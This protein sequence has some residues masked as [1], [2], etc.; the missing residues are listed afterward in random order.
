MCYG[1]YKQEEAAHNFKGT[2]SIYTIAWQEVDDDTESEPKIG[3]SEPWEDER[4]YIILSISSS[5][6][7]DP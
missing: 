2:E 6:N 3:Q 1:E 4:E 5:V 7:R